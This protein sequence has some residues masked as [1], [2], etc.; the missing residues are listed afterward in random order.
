M[1][2]YLDNAATTPLAPEV[3][4]AMLEVMEN[5]YGNPS[6]IHAY[7]RQARTLV[8]K[9]R[10]TVASLLN[11]APANIFLLLAVPKQ[12]IWQYVVL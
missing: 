12:I 6:S 9:A 8:E 10:K 3:K 11:T 2:I 5:E 1:K 4:Q 7:G